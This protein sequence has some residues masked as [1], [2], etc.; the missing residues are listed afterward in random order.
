MCI[1][2]GSDIASTTLAKSYKFDI[3]IE[4]AVRVLIDVVYEA[5]VV[6]TVNALPMTVV[7]KATGV[8][9]FSATTLE[10]HRSSRRDLRSSLVQL[11]ANIEASNGRSKKE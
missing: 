9:D 4:Q 5:S 7:V 2:S 1:G 8:N 6:P 10:K 11:A 3:T